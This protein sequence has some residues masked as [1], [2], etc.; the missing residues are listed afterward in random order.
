[1]NAIK[2]AAA[3]LLCISMAVFAAQAYAA[4]EEP[5]QTEAEQ[6]EPEL[7]GEYEA[8]KMIAEG[9]AGEFIDETLDAETI[10]QMG[11]S[12]LLDG[13]DDMLV[14]LLKKTLE[15]LD[16][17]S[18][19][20]TA[21]EYEEYINNLNRTFF[22]V[23]I[24]LKK[25]GQ[26]AEITG[27]AEADSLAE[28]SG[29]RVGDRII[30][31]GGTDVSSRSLEDIKNMLMG[32][33]NSTVTITVLRGDEYID[34]IATRTE[35]KEQTVAGE[36]L[37]G[38]VGYVRI[39]SFSEDTANEFY[40][41]N[42]LFETNGVTK[43]IMDLRDNPGG[44]VLSAVRIAQWIV[45]QGK[46]VDVKYRQP[47][48]D[49]VYYS[50]LPSTNK[51]YYVLV[52]GNTASAAEI[53]ASAMQDSGVGKLVGEQTFGKAVVQRTYPLNNGSVYKLTTAQYITRN[54]HHINGVGLTP[55]IEVK[56]LTEKID[57][58]LYT[59]MDFVNR[60]ALGSYGDTVK[61]AKER[62]YMLGIY[63]GKVDDKI[64]TEEL[65]EAVK[66]YQYVNN[67]S[68]SGVLDIITQTKLERTFSSLQ[69]VVDLQLQTAY[70]RFGG[71]ADDLN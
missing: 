18:T 64:F 49:T 26:Y 51:N 67:L 56:N 45:P 10:M 20:Y 8:W 43:I 52:N 35:V 22:G 40:E 63:K 50:E 30:R 19:F 15:S 60:Y 44:L 23:G 21:D 16:D 12:N 70:E 24:E 17:Y 66:E 7:S 9:I 57:T 32:E 47:E 61:G 38:N 39:V 5:L 3:W 54:G 25:T 34:I 55:D 65:Q 62:L 1:M 29:F 58:S 2:K 27:F 28:R 33:L 48:Y 37:P 14:A 31:I 59:P 41:V 71:N 53:L 46:I 69:R 36:L 4:E 68:A 6:T 13:D 42:K 11:I